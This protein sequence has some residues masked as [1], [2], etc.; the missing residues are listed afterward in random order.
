MRRS[1]LLFVVLA[2]LFI[3][4]TLGLCG[5]GE[6]SDLGARAVS[7]AAWPAEI[8]LPYLT[9]SQKLIVQASFSEGGTRDVTALV[10]TSSDA[11]KVA[12]FENG[13]VVAHSAGEATLTIRWGELAVQV[14]VTASAAGKQE[15]PLRFRNDILPVLTRS[16]C[17]TGKCHGAASGKD[18]FRLSLFGFDPEGDYFRIT[19]ELSGRRVNLAS[20]TRSLLV[21]KAIGEAPHTGGGPLALGSPGYRKLVTWLALGAPRDPEKMPI[22]VGIE[23]LPP[24]SVMSSPGQTSETTVV[25]SYSDGSRRDVTDLSVFISNNDAVVAT[26]AQGRLNGNGPGSAF[27]MAR[28][29]QFTAGRSIIV[30]PGKPFAPSDFTPANYIDELCLKRWNELHVHPSEVAD[31]ATFLRRIYLDAL[32]ALPTPEERASFLADTSSNKRERLTESLIGRKEFLDLWIMRLAELLQIRRAN[33]LSEKGLQLYDGWLREQIHDGVRV[34]ELVAELLQAKGSTFENPPASYFQTETTPQL[35]AENVAQAF[36]GM[37][38]QCAQCHNHPFDRWTMDDYYGFAAFVSQVG[39]KTGQDPREITIYDA[40]EGA[41]KHP[42]PGREV[43]PKFLGGGYPELKEGEDLRG[44]LARWLTSS[45][46]QAFANNIA[47]VVWQ[48]FMG[49]GIVS[50]VDDSRVSNPPCNPELLDELGRRL[51]EYDFDVRR[52]ADDICKSKTYQLSTQANDWNR[53]DDRHFSHARIRRL[54]AE[55]LLDCINQVTGESDEFTGLPLGGRAIQIPQGR[56][57][58]YFLTTFGRSDRSTPC[59]CEV[60]TEPTLSQ[61]LHLLNGE[62]TNAKIEKGDVIGNWLKASESP[63]DVAKRIYVTCYGREPTSKE[64]TAMEQ[65]FASSQ[66]VEAELSDLLWAVLNSNEFIF[67][68]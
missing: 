56:T 38:I 26:D 29:D 36:L 60:S 15:R 22:P 44:A 25:A 3:T 62:N 11:P 16:G 40:E 24:H 9:D 61:A 51:M 65:R 53:W 59:S 34:N 50:P 19:R 7:L 31:D 30:R 58:S 10:E 43:K 54:R 49:R 13:R 8:R 48:Q 18:G 33:G 32:G 52:L 12:T 45:D 28:F 64:R 63:M 66:D 42:I 46:N 68:H 23:V 14:P 4:P 57:N 17:N 27:V 2:V 21:Q 67:N 35:I 55:V 1:N 41:L 5:E 6:D 39:Y 47:N 20:P 37:R